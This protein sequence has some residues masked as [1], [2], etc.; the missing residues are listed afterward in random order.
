MSGTPDPCFQPVEVFRPPESCA[1]APLVFAS[2]HSGRHVPDGFLNEIAVDSHALRTSEDAFVDQLFQRTPEF[3]AVFIRA[4][5]ARAFIDPNRDP[6][7]LDPKM[8]RDTLPAW[9]NARSPRVANGLGAIPK[10]VADGRAIYRRLLSLDEAVDR[11]ERYHDPYHDA[12]NAEIERTRARHGFAILVDCHS[13]PSG[14]AGRADIVIGDRFGSSCDMRVSAAA[15]SA[16]KTL[17]YRMARNA[18]YAGG[19]TTTRYGQP[20][21]GV[22]AVQ[23]ELCRSLY[24]NEAL[25][26][27]RQPRFDRVRDRMSRLART[28]C[29]IDWKG[30]LATLHKKQP[31]LR[32]AE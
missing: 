19:F 15:E 11:I 22:H 14:G 1:A 13:M 3:G 18:P 27:P 24:M 4:N 5:F 7:E 30:R 8:F 10:V 21:A 9:A 31:R 17:G 28:L 2:P 16:L 25:I 26:A 32:A 20:H 12:L 29:E 6:W 23:I